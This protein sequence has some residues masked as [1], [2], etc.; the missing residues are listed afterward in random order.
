MIHPGDGRA[1]ITF[2]RDGNE[3]EMDGFVESMSLDCPGTGGPASASLHFAGTGPPEPVEQR[4][5]M[6]ILR[7]A[8]E[9]R[10]E[11]EVRELYPVERLT[12]RFHVHLPDPNDKRSPVDL[13]PAI[14]T[15]HPDE[16][17]LVAIANEI[18]HCLSP[19]DWVV[20]VRYAIPDRPSVVERP[21]PVLTMGPRGDRI[22]DPDEA[23]RIRRKRIRVGKALRFIRTDRE[24]QVV[25]LS[26]VAWAAAEAIRSIW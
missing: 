13:V 5:P 14:G 3:Y 2:Q 20:V 26:L 10:G 7:Q 17:K 24:F 9:T 4:D 22:F 25:A 11:P 1:K 21:T 18:E 6:A 8:V 23:R 16:F 12:R 15:R 19:V